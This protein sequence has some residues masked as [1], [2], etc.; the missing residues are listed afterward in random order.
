MMPQR[1]IL[2]VGL[3]AMGFPMATS[4]LRAG[5]DVIGVDRDATIRARFTGVGHAAIER[6]DQAAMIS[7]ML[8]AVVNDSQAEDV[9]FGSG[10]AVRRMR[11][12]AL[13]I[14]SLTTSP[15]AAAAIGEKLARHDILMID[16]PVS[17]GVKRAANGTLTLLVSGPPEAVDAARPYLDALGSAI[18]I[19]VKHGLA[20]RVK[21]LNQ[22]LC[23][24]HLAATA[25][26]VALAEKAG[27][28]PQLAYR[29]ITAS[30]GT[31]FMFA[32]RA[33][34]MLSP[35]DQV[36]AAIGILGKDLALAKAMGTGAGARTPLADC[37]LN[38]FVEAAERGMER[39][40]D[41][42]LVEIF[43]DS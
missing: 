20:S 37:T 16:C 21:L 15:E 24:I 12:G 43:R 8:L 6:P 35:A 4:L 38:L 25:E 10:G 33:P 22:M 29:A 27:I 40:D 14:L 5:I 2:I 28:D 30:S 18:I 32:D 19:G 34:R 17:G 36:G 7:A 42:R 9:L 13:V 11:A 3:G 1:P 23:G 41:T 26:I 31:S 39:L